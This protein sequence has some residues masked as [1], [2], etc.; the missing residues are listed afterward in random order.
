FPVPAGR[1]RRGGGP[2]RRAGARHAGRAGARHGRAEGVQRGRAA[3]RI[4][5]GQSPAP[6]HHPRLAAGQG[7]TR[8]PGRRQPGPPAGSVPAP[9]TDSAPTYSADGHWYWNGQQW[10]PVQTTTGAPPEP[11]AGQPAGGQGMAVTSLVLGILSPIF[12]FIPVIGWFF[13]PIPIVGL[14]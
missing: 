14:V 7:R 11:V 5:A 4:P 9:P 6:T 13:I 1:H 8:G 10:T 3:P 12:A 2:A